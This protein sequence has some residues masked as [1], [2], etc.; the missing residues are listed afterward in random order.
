[1]MSLNAAG[2]GPV[3]ASHH[4]APLQG[5]V[6]DGSVRRRRAQQ[7]GFLHVG[8]EPSHGEDV[9]QADG[10]VQSQTDGDEVGVETQRVT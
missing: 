5:R 10:L 3:S 2:H 4:A 1:M 8:A 6:A 7:D 9:Q